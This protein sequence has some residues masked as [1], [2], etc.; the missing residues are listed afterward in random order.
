[1]AIQLHSLVISKKRYIQVESLPHH[2]TGI[3]KKMMLDSQNIPLW[4]FSDTESA[5]YENEEDGTITFYQSVST[6][7]ASPG[8]WTYMM[9]ECP[10]GGEGVFTD[11]SFNTSIQPLKELFAGKKLEKSAVDIYEY[12]QYRYSDNDYLDIEIP[13]GWNKIVGIKIAD[14]LLEEYKA[15]KSTSIFAEGV[16]KR[17]AQIILDEFIKAGEEIIQN[18][19]R[20]EDFESDQYDI[21]NKIYID[22]MAKSIVEYND[23]RI[24]QAAL[25][26]KSKAVEYAFNTALSLISRIHQS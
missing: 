23:Y 4:Q 8:I 24:W 5:Y 12:L 17:Y 7:T 10:E 14:V 19:K 16:G 25:P 13:S 22:D 15:F 11:S 1:M 2:L 18:G 21:L 26:T 6:E 3:Y 20:L 9:Y